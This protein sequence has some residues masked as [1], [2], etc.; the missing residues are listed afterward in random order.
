[1]AFP[2]LYSPSLYS[3]GTHV[4]TEPNTALTAVITHVLRVHLLMYLLLYLRTYC[5]S[6]CTSCTRTYYTYCGAVRTA[7]RTY[8]TVD[9]RKFL[10]KKGAP[11]E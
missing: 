2:S 6:C 9:V 7:V 4:P 5:A 8:R 3:Y 10:E 11:A 1:M